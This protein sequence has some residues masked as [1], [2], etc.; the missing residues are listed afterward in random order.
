MEKSGLARL[1]RGPSGSSRRRFVQRKRC[2][3]ERP[4]D[5]RGDQHIC[6]ARLAD[7]NGHFGGGRNTFHVVVGEVSCDLVE[8][9]SDGPGGASA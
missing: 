6:L 1:I 4:S 2:C 9:A 8:M 5:I 3:M 7:D